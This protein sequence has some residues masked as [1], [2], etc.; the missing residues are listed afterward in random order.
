[1]NS[2]FLQRNQLR[3]IDGKLTVEKVVFE[4]WM[5]RCKLKELSYWNTQVAVAGT[6]A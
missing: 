2:F 4:S 6:L 5:L 1:M 3:D